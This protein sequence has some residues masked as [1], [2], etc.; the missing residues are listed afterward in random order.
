M[1]PFTRSNKQSSS[2]TPAQHDAA[3]VLAVVQVE[4]AGIPMYAR[5]Q[6]V[7]ALVTGV[8]KTRG[9]EL[10]LIVKIDGINLPKRVPD[11]EVVSTLYINE[12]A[13][14]AAFAALA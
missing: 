12:A 4:Y 9:G 6:L 5:R 1:F 11:T 7:T 3:N 8:Q 10:E 14:S 13:A 2:Q